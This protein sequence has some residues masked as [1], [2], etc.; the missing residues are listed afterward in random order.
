MS[1]PVALLVDALVGHRLNNRPPTE[2]STPRVSALSKLRGRNTSAPA[3]LEDRLSESMTRSAFAVHAFTEAAD[4]L[5]AAASEQENVI[6]DI[7]AEVDRLEDLQE[8]AFQEIDAARAISSR[9]RGL[10]EQ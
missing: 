7:Q 2:R 4:E 1:V 9:L 5:D 6:A 8:I 3:S 10:V